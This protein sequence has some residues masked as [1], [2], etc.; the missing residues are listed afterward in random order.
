[1]YTLVEQAFG[2]RLRSLAC[3]TYLSEVFPTAHCV[4]G[5]DARDWRPNSGRV[6]G[7][8]RSGVMPIAEARHRVFHT[9]YA[10]DVQIEYTVYAN[11]LMVPGP[12]GPY[13]RGEKGA[14]VVRSPPIQGR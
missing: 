4:R 11:T 12:L 5:P 2:G 13:G 1:M 9:Y 10:F 3:D 14:E 7:R 6:W 8:G